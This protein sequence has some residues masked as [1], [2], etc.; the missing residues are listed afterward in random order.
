MKTFDIPVHYRSAL[1]SLVKEWRNKAH[2]RKDFTPTWLDFGPLQ[3]GLPRHFGFCFGVERAVERVYKAL[4][5]HPGQRLFLVSEMIHN[6]DV[7]AHLLDRGIRFLASP[8]G[9]RLFDWQTLTPDDVVII[10]AFGATV[11]VMDELRALGV[12]LQEYDTTCPFVVKVWRRSA[13]LGG[14]Q[15][16]VV[17]HGKHEHEET[18]ATFS[19][20][21]GPSLIVRDLAET[22]FLVE[23]ILGNRS[24]E[25]FH[26]FFRGRYSSG[27][28]PERDLSRIGVVNQTTMLASETEE[29]AR[30]IQQA[31]AT[32]YGKDRLPHHFADTSDTLCY[33]TNEN[34]ASALA[35]ASACAD[36][37]FVVGG[38]NSSNTR[39]LVSIFR[40]HLPTYFIRNAGQ[41]QPDGTVWHYDS[42]TKTEIAD[43]LD[44]LK[45]SALQQ[46]PVRVILA[47]GA[48]C[49]DSTLEEVLD[50]LVNYL[51]GITDYAAVLHRLQQPAA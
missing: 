27:F 47:S 25:E 6:P 50:W 10:P 19:R 14:E 5:E 35:L 41:F 22:G 40:Q 28:D 38:Y 43:S 4:E 48:S 37:A 49:P 8:S 45:T 1:V 39:Q 23:C 34:Q 12:N 15:H 13:E 18:R 3:V 11:E 17:V 44:Y 46:P 16:T 29:V 24:P 2:A 31:L 21:V 32:R 9:E 36:A 26:A 33:A 42:Q 30:R 7:N 51:G 20:Q